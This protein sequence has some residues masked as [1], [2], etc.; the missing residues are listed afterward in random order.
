MLS[1]LLK[2]DVAIAELSTR[3]E[4]KKNEPRP[5]IGF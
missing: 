1:G 5:K 2:S 4:E 3:I